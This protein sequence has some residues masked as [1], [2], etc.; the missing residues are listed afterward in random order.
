MVVS[1]YP[2][3]CTCS[4]LRWADKRIAIVVIFDC[5]RFLGDLKDNGLHQADAYG[6]PPNADGVS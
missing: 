5:D 3:S 2:S 1:H 6:A 4:G